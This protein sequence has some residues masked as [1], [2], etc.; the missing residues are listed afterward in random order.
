MF[1][2]YLTLLYQKSQFEKI[3]ELCSRFIDE[4]DVDGSVL[5]LLHNL[6]ACCHVM[7]GKPLMAIIYWR[8]AVECSNEDYY[9]L[10]V[11]YNLHI[12]YKECSMLQPA[13]EIINILVKIVQCK[14]SANCSSPFLVI[15]SKN[16]V[17]KVKPYS[18]RKTITDFC[19]L[20][21]YCAFYHLHFERYLE[22][23]KWFNSFF[24]DVDGAY[25]IGLSR[26]AS[27]YELPVVAPSLMQIKSEFALALLKCK[28]ASA[29]LDINNIEL[30]FCSATFIRVQSSYYKMQSQDPDCGRVFIAA[31]IQLFY[32]VSIL[33]YKIV[34]YMKTDCSKAKCELENCLK[35]LES[36]SPSAAQGIAPTTNN[37]SEQHQLNVVLLRLSSAKAMVYFNYALLL[38]SLSNQEVSCSYII[39][40]SDHGKCFR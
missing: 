25:H 37:I 38:S 16:D 24:D 23:V 1:Y 11:L 28:N 3:L 4:K 27:E 10:P 29:L 13:S 19:H 32:C 39:F 12:T 34:V 15:E 18:Y 31:G 5:I 8:K 40:S 14:C 36:V 9:V 35:A 33:L 17:L 6:V 7:L 20:V 2:L 22:A 26:R 21:Y 30:T